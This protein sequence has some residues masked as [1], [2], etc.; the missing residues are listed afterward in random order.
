[1]PVVLGKKP[2]CSK[3]FKKL[4]SRISWNPAGKGEQENTLSDT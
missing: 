4:A 3:S 1:M 2:P